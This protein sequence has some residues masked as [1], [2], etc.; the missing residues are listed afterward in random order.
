MCI[1]LEYTVYLY[2][3]RATTISYRN[4]NF[5]YHLVWKKCECNIIKKIYIP[6]C[7]YMHNNYKIQKSLKYTQNE[8]F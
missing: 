8:L 2:D 3:I 4:F 1:G 6:C 5:Y 7:I